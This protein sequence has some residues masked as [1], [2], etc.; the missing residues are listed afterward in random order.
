MD[1]EEN[2]VNSMKASLTAVLCL[3]FSISSYAQVDFEA[4][5]RDLDEASAQA[6]ILTDLHF[7]VLGTEGVEF[8]NGVNAIV[9]QGIGCDDLKDLLDK[10]R[11]AGISERKIRS[12]IRKS[13]KDA[14]FQKLREC[15]EKNMVEDQD[16]SDL[17]DKAKELKI[18]K[19]E[20]EQEL[21]FR[22]KLR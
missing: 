9:W 4:L 17:L 21:G 16:C 18:S 14:L 13:Q 20:L 1:R 11:Q 5:E 12:T 2:R 19:T 10:A 6:S 22:Y 8:A 15:L 3:L 7:C